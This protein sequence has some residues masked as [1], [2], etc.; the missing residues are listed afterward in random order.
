MNSAIVTTAAP[1]RSRAGRPP[2]AVALARAAAAAAAPWP[3]LESVTTPT[4]STR[5]A[6]HYAGRSV[7]T[8]LN[9]ARTKPSCTPP[10]RP[11]RT[12]PGSPLLWRVADL[13]RLVG[14]S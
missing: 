7:A 10:M 11:L 3:P 2:V 4:V 8:M 9:W 1:A 13:R 14:A 12:S 6:A 5:Q